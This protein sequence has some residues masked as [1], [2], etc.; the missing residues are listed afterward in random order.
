[1]D[2][3]AKCYKAVRDA[4]ICND[5]VTFSEA[6]SVLAVIQNELLTQFQDK[7]IEMDDSPNCTVC[8]IQD[9]C[10]DIIAFDS[11]MCRMLYKTEEL[12]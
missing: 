1:M 10:P 7:L 9:K 5:D 4:T 8:P 12:S 11:M 3:I 6:I 2:A